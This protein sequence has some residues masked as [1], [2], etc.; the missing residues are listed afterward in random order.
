[1]LATLQK[2]GES[3]SAQ[4]NSSAGSQ[5]EEARPKVQKAKIA[6]EVQPEPEQALDKRIRMTVVSYPPTS[7]EKK[8]PQ[9]PY[10]DIGVARSRLEAG[11]CRVY[12]RVWVNGAGEIV[13][14]E[15][16]SPSTPEDRKKYEPFIMA[17][18]DSVADWQF[19]QVEAQVHV[20][21]LFEIK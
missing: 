2:T 13:R 6:A 12:Y 18:K 5:A 9:V 7:V 4:R 19:D 1:M 17:V 16:K 21:V 15:V 20:D 14:D 11:I 8:F 10:P 3:Q